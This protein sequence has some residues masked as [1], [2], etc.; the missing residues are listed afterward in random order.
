MRIRQHLATPCADR[1][2]R[3]HPRPAR[4]GDDLQRPTLIRQAGHLLAQQIADEDRRLRARAIPKPLGRGVRE[5][6]SL[7]QGKNAISVPVLFG[8]TF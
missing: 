4:N 2:L 6:Q 7:S 1:H 3:Q 5:W 8:L